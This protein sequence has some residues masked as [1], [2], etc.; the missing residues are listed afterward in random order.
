M[1][2]KQ[3]VQRPTS[4]AKAKAIDARLMFARYRLYILLSVIGCATLA[5]IL[6]IFFG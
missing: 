5:L 6:R 4:G 3:P 2:R 1:R